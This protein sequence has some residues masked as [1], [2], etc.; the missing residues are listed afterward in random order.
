MRISDWSSDVCSSDLAIP[1]S[2]EPTLPPPRRDEL[3][4]RALEAGVGGWSRRDDGRAIDAGGARATGTDGGPMQTAEK[5][6]PVASECFVPPG[7]PLE[8]QTI[9]RIVTERPGIVTALVTRDVWRPGFDCLAVPA[10]S[11]SAD[12]RV[13]KG[14]GR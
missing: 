7:T 3:W 8:A 14:G 6:A 12:R 10:C 11:P 9:T 5:F 4:D 2:V 13:G 1:R